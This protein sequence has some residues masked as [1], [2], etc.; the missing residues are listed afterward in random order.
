MQTVTVEGMQ[1]QPQTLTVRRGDR[2]RWV[3]KDLFPHTVTAEG[4]GFDSPEIAPRSS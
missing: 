1:Y 3:N 4:G 2:I